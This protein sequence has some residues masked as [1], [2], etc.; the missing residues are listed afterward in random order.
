[1]VILEMR[2]FG[3]PPEQ[4]LDVLGGWKDPTA[5]QALL[6]ALEPYRV[7]ELSPAT[8]RSLSDLL[9]K[10]I[11]EGRHQADRGTAEWLMRR[12]GATPSWTSCRTT[13]AAR[14]PPRPSNSGTATGGSPLMA[15]R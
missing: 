11:R 13:F 2:D 8:S 15:T 7:R 12:W 4:V 1:M 9:A 5:R 14:R 10:Q 3:I 6:L